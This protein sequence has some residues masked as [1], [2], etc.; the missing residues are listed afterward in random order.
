[1]NAAA[2]PLA[3]IK[4]SSDRHG[5]ECPRRCANSFSLAADIKARPDRYRDAL[6]GRFLAHDF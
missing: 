4:R 1:M 3:L 6:A 5:V 2:A